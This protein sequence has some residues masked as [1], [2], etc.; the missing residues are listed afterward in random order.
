MTCERDKRI[1]S[2]QSTKK[3]ST[4]SERGVWLRQRT[5]KTKK[6]D[7]G[8]TNSQ[9]SQRSPKYPSFKIEDKIPIIELTL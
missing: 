2:C 3:Q 7:R 8:R 4:E 1:N 5:V 6:D 9:N